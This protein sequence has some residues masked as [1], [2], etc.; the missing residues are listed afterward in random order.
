MISFLDYV[1][2]IVIFILGLPANLF[3]LG[4]GGFDPRKSSRRRRGMERVG[5]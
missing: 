5:F 3:L 4:G 2:Y 1:V